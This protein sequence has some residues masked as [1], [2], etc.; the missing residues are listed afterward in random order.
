MGR[1]Q[2]RQVIASDKVRCPP[3][4]ETRVYKAKLWNAF[5]Y[6]RTGG[7]GYVITEGDG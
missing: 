2:L 7:K 1:F 4:S 5:D 6:V 3:G